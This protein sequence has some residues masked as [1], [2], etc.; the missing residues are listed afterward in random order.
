MGRDARDNEKRREM[1]EPFKFPKQQQPVSNVPIV[2]QPFQVTAIG[3]PMNAAIT[4]NA[5]AEKLTINMSQPVTCPSC[6]KIYN[7]VFNPVTMQP[8]AIVQGPEEKPAS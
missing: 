2:G 4:C 8:Q 3:I 1:G 5:D 6:G 7:L